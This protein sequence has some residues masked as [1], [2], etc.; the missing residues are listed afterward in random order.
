MSS[1]DRICL[2][3]W[4]TSY[5]DNNIQEKCLETGNLIEN[6]GPCT[7]LPTVD[8]CAVSL[9]EPPDATTV[10]PTAAPDD[11]GSSSSTS[12]SPTAAP[13][14]SGSTTTM[15]PTD[16]ETTPSP[17]SAAVP[18]AQGLHG[19]APLFGISLVVWMQL[20]W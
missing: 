10:S 19:W 3:F 4:T 11:S 17:T 2:H 1:F 14:D 9:A 5:L 16:D 18:C 6:G 7:A 20:S 12:K 13:N 8:S 15:N